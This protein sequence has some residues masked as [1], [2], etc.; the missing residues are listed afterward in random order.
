MRFTPQEH[1]VLLV[2]YN[3]TEAFVNNPLNGEKAQAA[4]IGPFLAS[5]NQLGDQA[6]TVAPVKKKG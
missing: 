4:P 3:G 6:L 1:A 5:W 2:G